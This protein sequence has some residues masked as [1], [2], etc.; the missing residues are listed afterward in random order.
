M[1]LNVFTRG[2]PTIDPTGKVNCRFVEKYCKKLEISWFFHDKMMQKSVKFNGSFFGRRFG[3]YYSWKVLAKPIRFLQ[4][5]VFW[6]LK[7]LFILKKISEFI[8]FPDVENN[9]I[10]QWNSIIISI[11]QSKMKNLVFSDIWENIL[12]F[13]KT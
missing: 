10:F 2:D 9:D 6:K 13:L 12:L 8:H 3:R 4:K 1:S 11:Y 7:M 5:I